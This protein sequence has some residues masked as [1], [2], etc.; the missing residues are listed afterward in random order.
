MNRI[1]Y[2]TADI[3]LGSPIDAEAPQLTGGASST[4]LERMDTYVHNR[5]S[6]GWMNTVPLSTNK[7]VATLSR[8]SNTPTVAAGSSSEN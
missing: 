5:T 4:V 8:R 6:S 3:V 7:S 2:V 1:D